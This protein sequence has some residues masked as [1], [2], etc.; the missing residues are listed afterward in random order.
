MVQKPME[1]EPVLRDNS[2][3]ERPDRRTRRGQMGKALNYIS[4]DLQGE[5]IVVTIEEEDIKKNQNYWATAIIGFVLGEN[6]YFKSMENYVDNVWDFVDTPKILYHDKGY[7]IFRFDSIDD[8]NKVMQSGPYFFHN[9]P[10]ILKNW[11]LDFVFNPE[12]LNVI[13]IWVRFPNLPVGFWSTEA[14]SKMASGIGKPM[15][16]DLYT[17]EMDR[18]SYAR[19]LVEAD[20][21]HP[22]PNDILLRTPV[23]VIHQSI[24]YEWQPKFCMDCIKVGHTTDECRKKKEEGEAGEYELGYTEGTLPFKYLG[25]PLAPKKLS[26]HQCWPLVEKI[27]AKISCWTSKL[28]SYAG[29][30]QLIKAVMFGMQSY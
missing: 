12:C 28:L 30:L 21:S 17:A 24:E 13:P 22:L 14:L 23:G 11:S 27:T 1:Q 9:K 2:S 18:I 16:T 19:V 25:V 20:I 3:E 10:F 7:Y 26:V 15:Y 29:R 5:Q 8:R 6:P 4:P